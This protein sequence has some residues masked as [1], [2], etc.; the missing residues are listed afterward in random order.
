MEAPKYLLLFRTSFVYTHNLKNMSYPVLAFFMGL[1]GSLHCVV[2]CGPLMLALPVEGKRWGTQA[3][4]KLLYQ[5]GRILSY[6]LIG[7]I[8]GAL[9]QG[10]AIQGW[11]QALSLM[12]GLVLIIMALVQWVGTHS[13]AW[14]V[15]QQRLLQPIISRMS[16]W[17]YRPG[18]SFMAGMLNG[19]LP[20][21]MVY[22]AL[23]SALSADT[24]WSGATFM[25]AFGLGT[26]PLLWLT[27]LLGQWLKAKK[28]FST[29]KYIPFLMLLLGLWFLLRGAN[30]DIPY[31]S[32]LLY[33]EGAVNCA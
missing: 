5:I 29:K 2:M 31:L 12:T 4:Q 25:M 7:G 15:T 33:P 17:F 19:F 21:G 8:L 28:N 32:P 16:Y 20:C 1:F 23:I 9:G 13:S 26:L 18:G 6:A 3:L 24:A 14:V 22:M 11:Q 30:L 27:T 10:F